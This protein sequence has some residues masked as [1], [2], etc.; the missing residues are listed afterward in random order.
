MRRRTGFSLVELLVVLAVIAVLLGFLLPAVQK[1]R[2]S[3]N[4]ARCQNNLRQIGM[5]LHMY[6]DSYQSFPWGASDDYKDLAGRDFSSL[7][8]G[9]YVLPYLEQAP[10]YKRFNTGFNFTLGGQTYAQ[11]L[12]VTFNNPPNNTNSTDPDLNPAAT[13]LSVFQCPSSP[14]R[15]AAY[16]D[17]W[18]NNP[19]GPT[20]SSG[21]YSGNTSWTVSASDYMACSG[22][23]DSFWPNYVPNLNH[24][25]GILNNNFNVDMNMIKDGTSSTWLVGEVAGAPDIW[26]AGPTRIDGPP[27]TNSNHW[28]VCG[29]GWA[30]ETNGDA[31]LQGNSYDGTNPGGGGPCT[32]NCGNM[33]AGGFFS[34]HPQQA[35]FLY[36]DG[37]VAPVNQNIDPRVTIFQLCFD[38]GSFVPVQN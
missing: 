8:W 26:V 4:R 29:N 13:P 18:S 38:D 33:S 28:T 20:N 35:N 2:E 5:A 10:L 19:L 15:G 11:G 37:H 14:S 1:A 36:A 34:F 6:H 24:K 27:Y 23:L 31:W 22:V 12:A 30:D 32:V 17:T 25:E 9:V 21:P 3:V 7:P 16:T